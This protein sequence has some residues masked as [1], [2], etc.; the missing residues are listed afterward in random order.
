M[1]PPSDPKP[2]PD[3]N[4][5]FLQ[6]PP[7]LKKQKQKQNKKA[8]PRQR[9]K[10]TATTTKPK[11]KNMPGQLTV[12]TSSPNQ[13]HHSRNT[14]LS[15]PGHP[16]SGPP[17]SPITPTSD[18][19][20]LATPAQQNAPPRQTYTHSQPAQTAIP[21][22]V[23][24]PITLNENTDAIALKAAMSIL[25]MQARNAEND[26][27]QLARMKEKAVANPEAF[28]KALEA[29][30][31]RAKPGSLFAPTANNNDVGD[32]DEDEDEDDDE[33]EDQD[34][35]MGNTNDQPSYT[36]GASPQQNSEHNPF[37]GGFTFDGSVG[38]KAPSFPGK[39]SPAKESKK[40]EW[41]ELPEPQNV[42]RCPPINWNKYAVVGDS[43]DKLHADQQK[44]P[45][46]GKPQVIGADGTLHFGGDSARRT[47][48]GVA[49]PYSPK[50]KV[51]KTST[52]K[53][54][55]R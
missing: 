13:S 7:D 50:D 4:P 2:L 46:E 38:P 19:A 22:P 21:Q 16:S 8:A 43:L 54:G 1:A 11:E 40:K 31:V 30:E 23:P 14:S 39:A 36:F 26:I 27:K 18:F 35:A 37:S 29:G 47:V 5:N 25:Q 55:K 32:D 52:R 15:S 6:V 24:I 49:S 3:Q 45:T 20:Q 44:R 41:G 9:K 34:V 33:N 53:G 12:D 10:K 42:V 28:V 17:Y 48:E 51:D